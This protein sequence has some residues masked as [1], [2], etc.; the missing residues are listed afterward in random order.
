MSISTSSPLT[1][2]ALGNAAIAALILLW[3]LVRRPPLGRGTKFALLAGLGVFPIATAATGN[4]AGYEATKQR[5]FCGACHVMGPWARDSE[6]P[7]SK[8]LAARHARNPTF[9]EENCYRCHEDYGKLGAVTTKIGGMKH[10]YMFLF[11]G[12]NEMS[13]DEA[14][15]K[16]RIAKPYP[17][18]NCMQCH[19]TYGNQW[20][21]QPDHARELDEIRGG[22]V[23]CASDGC[24]GP[25]HPFSHGGEP[26][27]RE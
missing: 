26:A 12:Y 5:T 16:I 10:V 7:D 25:A 17:N 11:K 19:S 21:D 2:V 18:S 3:Y 20:L 1:W 27:G 23:S 13:D 6:D 9:G 14:V 4:V 22:A 15:Q 8:S 24:H